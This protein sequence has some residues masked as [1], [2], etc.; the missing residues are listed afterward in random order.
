MIDL[1]TECIHG[2]VSSDSINEITKDDK[3]PSV[4]LNP[5]ERNQQQK[6]VA[7]DSNDND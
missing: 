5:L 4:Y 2:S 7:H 1:S 6:L 3:N